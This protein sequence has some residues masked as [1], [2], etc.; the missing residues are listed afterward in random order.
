MIMREQKR[1]VE[2]WAPGII[3]GER[4]TEDINHSDPKK[5]EWPANAYAFAIFERQDIIEDGTRYEGKAKQIGPLYYHPDSRI[6][7][8][9]Q[10]ESKG[11]EPILIDNMKSNKMD[12]IIWTRWNNWPQ[13]YNDKK[14]RILT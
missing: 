7:T 13:P 5:V 12:K 1:W 2:Y 4:W 9:E 14:I 11:N 8:L 3:V 10:V 6:E